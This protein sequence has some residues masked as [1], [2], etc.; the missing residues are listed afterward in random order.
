MSPQQ[1]T[2]RE[3]LRSML[4]SR[5][6]QVFIALAAL[7]LCIALALALW[8]GRDLI[9]GFLVVVLVIFGIHLARELWPFSPGARARWEHSRQLANRYPSYR[10]RPFLGVG[11]GLAAPAIWRSYTRGV[12]QP[13]DFAL[14]AAFVCVGVVSFAVW[15]FRK[16]KRGVTD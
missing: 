6:A 7:A 4:R 9:A 11:I 13:W 1:L 8:H 2:R 15:H 16:G 10:Y 3:L 5:F 12:F 14:A